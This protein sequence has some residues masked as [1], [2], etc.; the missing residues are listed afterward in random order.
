[1]GVNPITHSAKASGKQ[2]HWTRQLETKHHCIKQQATARASTNTTTNH[3]TT[4]RLTATGEH[5]SLAQ[6]NTTHEERP[7]DTTLQ[8]TAQRSTTLHS[9][10]RH[11][12]ANT[13]T[14]QPPMKPTT[15]NNNTR[16]TRAPAHQHNTV[17]HTTPHNAKQCTP[18][19]GTMQQY[20]THCTTPGATAGGENSSTAPRKQHNTA[21]HSAA[22][23]MTRCART[24]QNT[25]HK[26]KAEHKTTENGRK[27]HKKHN[28]AQ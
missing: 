12:T 1:M 27:K 2:H 16:S 6:H 10:Y 4:P 18:D 24:R 14:G 21:L 11:G 23:T 8:Q 5:T 22:A 3:H 7:K 26:K 19:Q 20:A 25:T 28:K 13:K 15:Q 9:I 17:Q